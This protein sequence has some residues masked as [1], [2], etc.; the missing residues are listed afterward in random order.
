MIDDE[1]SLHYVVGLK[2]F[3]AFRLE[4]ERAPCP[5]L[6]RRRYLGP[7][8]SWRST[9]EAGTLA[10][11]PA[12]DIGRKAGFCVTVTVCLARVSQMT[13]ATWASLRPRLSS[14]NPSTS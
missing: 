8:D 3:R 11:I 1:S 5:S 13:E 14:P 2:T 10:G 9:R 12:A 7:I 6:P 4:S